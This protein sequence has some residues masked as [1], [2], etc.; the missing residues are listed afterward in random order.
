MEVWLRRHANELL[1]L[2]GAVITIVGLASFRTWRDGLGAVGWAVRD[3]PISATV[4]ALGVLLFLAANWDRLRRLIWGVQRWP[5]DAALE[6]ELNKWMRDAGWAVQNLKRQPGSEGKG[7][8]GFA[9]VDEQQRIVNITK[10]PGT[11]AIGLVSGFE[12][13]DESVA[14]LNSLTVEEQGIVVEDIGLEMA[15]F[16]LGFK[17]SREPKWEIRIND[18]VVVSDS[19]MRAEFFDHV[20]SV[21]RA[22]LLAQI[23]FARHVRAAQRGKGVTKLVPIPQSDSGTEDSPTG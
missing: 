5:S 18:G 8:F 13:A 10:E 22:L 3:N 4:L 20:T 15:R 23:T 7:G 9:A 17:V 16:G 21:V 1:G 11:G 2:G 12:P 6:D 14:V 19:L